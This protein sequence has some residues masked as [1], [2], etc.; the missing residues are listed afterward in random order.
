MTTIEQRV[1]DGGRS[2][3]TARIR[4]IAYWTGTLLLA[5][6]MIGGAYGEITRQYG[7]LETH[8][9]LGY[10]T[11][12]LSIIAT[13]KLL[14]S[15]AILVPRF[16][17]LKEWAYAGMF[18]NMSG[19]FISHLVQHDYGTGGYHLVVTAIITLLVVASW[20]LRPP[21]RMPRHPGIDH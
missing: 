18:F 16:G 21:N 4:T 20:A 5:S 2:S 13:W 14:G 9:I 17:L 3:A 19:A 1:S 12:V 6:I 11:Y 7:T 8:T 15:I 10:P